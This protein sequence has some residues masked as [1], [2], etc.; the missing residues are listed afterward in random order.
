MQA[1]K[2]GSDSVVIGLCKYLL[3]DKKANKL[4]QQ[5]IFMIMVKEMEKPQL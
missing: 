5:K 1:K 4:C 3:F 2:F